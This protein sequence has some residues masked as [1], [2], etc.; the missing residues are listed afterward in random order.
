VVEKA[1]GPIGGLHMFFLSFGFALV[2]CLLSGMIHFARYLER[3]MI[4]TGPLSP[5]YLFKVP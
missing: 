5:K 4:N 1:L 3:K 2:S